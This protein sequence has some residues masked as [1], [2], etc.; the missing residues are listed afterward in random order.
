[1]KR[2]PVRWIA[3]GVLVVI[4]GIVAVLATRP[5]ATATEVITPLVGKKAPPIDATTV[6][7]A[8]FRLSAYRGRFVVL[9]FFATW[10]PPCRTEEPH[11]VSFAYQHRSPAGPALVGVVFADTASNARAFFASTGATWPAVADP[12]GRIAL[13]YGVRGPPETFVIAPDGLVVAHIDGPVTARYLDAVLARE[14]G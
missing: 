10:C 2:S 7:G 11:L 13:A 12:S 14:G 5:Q 4:A 6:T 8:P 3:V 9:N 1:M